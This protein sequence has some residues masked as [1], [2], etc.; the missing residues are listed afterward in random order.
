MSY[1]QTNFSRIGG[2]NPLGESSLS[3]FRSQWTFSYL[4]TLP[5]LCLQLQVAVSLPVEFSDVHPMH[6]TIHARHSNE[7]KLKARCPPLQ[8]FIW[9]ILTYLY[10]A[11]S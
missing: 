11:Y 9:E 5:P 4:Q 10:L 3:L 2:V 1:L 6:L 8:M 7:E